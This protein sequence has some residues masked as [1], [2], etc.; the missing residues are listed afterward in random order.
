[1][2]VSLMVGAVLIFTVL[3]FFSNEKLNELPEYIKE[4]YREIASA[5]AD[6]V[7][8]ELNGFVEQIKIVSQSSVVKSMDLSVI[9]EYLPSLVLEGKHHNMTIATLDGK[10]WTTFGMDIDILQQEQYQKIIIEQQ[11]Y[12]ISQ[13]FV[14]PYIDRNTPITIIS[15][16]IKNGEETVGLVNIVVEVE[17]LNRIVRQMDLKERAY[18]WIVNRDGLIVAHPDSSVFMDSRITDYIINNNGAIESILDQGSGIVEYTNENHEEMLALFQRIDGAPGWTFIISIPA[19]E[20]FAEVNGV[21]NTILTAIIIGLVLIFAFSVLYSRSISKPI[22]KLKEVFEKAANGNLNVKADEEVPNEIGSAA[23]SFNQ[24]LEKIKLLTYKDVVTGLNNNNGFFLELPYKLK[25]LKEKDG[26]IAIVIISIDDF[27]RINSIS[28]YEVGNQVLQN[29]AEG[30]GSFINDG[31]G[32]ARFFGDEFIVVLWEKNETTLDQRI[33]ELWQQCSGEIN[34]REHEFI[35][36]TS[37]GSSI[38]KKH[39]DENR[40]IEQAVYE[41][42]IAKLTVK[43]AGGNNYQFYNLQIDELIKKEQEI[44]NELYHAIKN[45]QLYLVY[46]PIIEVGTKKIIGI[47]AL[48]RWRHEKYDNISPLTLIHIAEQR[49]F[50]AEI[51]EWVLKEACKQNKQWQQEGYD[52]MIVSVNVSPLQLEQ[53]NFVEM[54]QQV[55][56]ETGLEPNYLEIEITESNAM[57]GVDEKLIKIKQI[58][59]MGV[60]IAIDD[61]GTGYSSLAYFTQFPI[62]TLKVDRSFINNMLNDENAKTIVATIITM[63]QSMKIKTTAEGVESIE[64]LKHLQERGC[65]LIQGYLISKPMEPHLVEEMFHKDNK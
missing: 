37:I 16:A 10:G 2:L 52:D 32:V 40:L 60:G 44:E 65:D 24:M 42:T 7:S 8:K 18:G 53:G 51:G 3:A 56:K 54:L 20:V 19:E 63:A 6:E 57:T 62:D 11:E 30:L 38:M 1:M 61:F 58:K 36:K 26:V 43:K 41:A 33:L 48:L 39:D 23:K 21:R 64:Q 45:Q 12:H 46:Q 49:G 25:M 28:G 5:K 29:L 22:L 59:E 35:I 14:S 15:H 31:E 47:E 13:P 27:K 34:V 9:K 55:L 50:I 4:Q 17:F